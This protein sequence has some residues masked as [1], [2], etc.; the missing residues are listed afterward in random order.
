M[1][2]VLVWR[3]GENIKRLMAGSESKLGSNAKAAE[4]LHGQAKR[5]HAKPHKKP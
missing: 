1:A 3:H 2:F 4:P 5:P